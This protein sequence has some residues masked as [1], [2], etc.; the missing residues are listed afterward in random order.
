MEAHGRP[1]GAVM[2]NCRMRESVIMTD[3]IM[4]QVRILPMTSS[5][6]R[7]LVSHK[8]FNFEDK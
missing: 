2:D 6:Y 1:P 7:F 8:H 3:L 5:Y 4:L